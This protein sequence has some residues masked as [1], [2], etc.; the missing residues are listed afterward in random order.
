M[1]D[2]SLEDLQAAL[3]S[4]QAQKSTIRLSERNVVE[5]VSKLQQL[6]LL[7]DSLLHSTSGK[8]YLTVEHLRR[9]LLEAVEEAGGRESLIELAG[10]LGVDIVHCQQEATAAVKESRGALLEVH[11]QLITASYLDG[12]ASEVQESLQEMGCVRLGDVARRF[13]LNTDLVTSTITARLGSSIHGKLDQQLLY[14]AAH[15][16]RIKARVRGALAGATFPIAAS[17]LL[18]ELGLEGA[19]A[20][21]GFSISS[22]VEELLAEGQLR[23][24]YKASTWTPAIYQEAQQAALHRT[25]NQDGYVRYEEAASFGA[26]S[27]KAHLQ[28]AFPEGIALD[29]GIVSPSVIDHIDAGL[30]EALSNSSWVDA[31]TLAPPLLLSSDVEQLLSRSASL[32]KGQQAGTHAAVHLAG[33]CVV[34]SALLDTLQ[35]KANALAEEA[36]KSTQQMLLKPAGASQPDA[37][38]PSPAS[39]QRECSPTT[40]P[41]AKASKDV[42][43]DDWESDV[44]GK[45]GSKRKSGKKGGK[46]SN[47]SP[48]PEPPSAASKSSTAARSK[49]TPAQQAKDMAAKQLS[50]AALQQQVL[51]W[52]PDMEAAGSEAQLASELA[53]R[54]RPAA[55]AEL[56][57]ALSRLFASGNESRKQL[58]AQLLSKAESEM[59]QLQ[60]FGHGCDACSAD[61]ELYTALQR[62]LVRST[63]QELLDLLLSYHEAMY[64]DQMGMSAATSKQ[65][66]E[67]SSSRPAAEWVQ[68]IQQLPEDASTAA[69]SAMQSVQSSSDWQA[70]SAQLEALSEAAGLRA[71]K[72]DKKAERSLVHLHCKALQEQL[73]SEENPPAALSLAVPLLFIRV[74]HKA[75]LVPGRCLLGIC[76]RLSASLDEHATFLLEFHDLVVASLKGQGASTTTA[77][78]GTCD[79]KLQQQLPRLKVLAA[80]SDSIVQQPPSISNTL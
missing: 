25:Y 19:G 4:A 65:E 24:S 75:L 32:S 10:Q 63:G 6:G 37:A 57:K 3:A 47:P 76:Q 12:L 8:E 53:A 59:Q 1:E 80:S 55:L 34:S 42:P 62:H 41:I 5:L 46:G 49:Q 9:E 72:L 64:Q 51:E 11:G 67:S 28:A 39:R 68:L 66:H 70:C 74:H 71:R 54:L 26:A 52:Q 48:S 36:A 15:M 56:D 7:G 58:K 13:S 43:D 45:R 16:R 73:Q 27:G 44:K 50:L 33:T 77:S 31:S 35:G 14:T 23:G 29:A 40:P 22:L 61:E 78:A 21:P 79:E 20:L 30:D 38:G 69:A 60:M 18:K 17:T 2:F